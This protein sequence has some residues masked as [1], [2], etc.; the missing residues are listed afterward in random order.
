MVT[1]HLGRQVAACARGAADQTHI[2]PPS[3]VLL[4]AHKERAALGQSSS[5]SPNYRGLTWRES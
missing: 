3:T 1:E 2:T 4:S 5:S